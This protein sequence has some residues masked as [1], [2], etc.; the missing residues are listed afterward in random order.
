MVINWGAV[1]LGGFL[2]KMVQSTFMSH[3][4]AACRSLIWKHIRTNLLVR[5]VLGA[6][7]LLPAEFPETLGPVRLCDVPGIGRLYDGRRSSQ[8]DSGASG[9][10]WNIL[11]V[12]LLEVTGV[13]APPGTISLQMSEEVKVHF[14]QTRRKLLGL[15]AE[16]TY[17]RW[18]Y[19][20]GH[21]RLSLDAYNDD[22]LAVACFLETGGWMYFDDARNVLAV[23]TVAPA[24][25]RTPETM[26]FKK[27]AWKQ[28]WTE[29]LRNHNRFHEVTLDFMVEVGARYFVW[30][31]PH[32]QIGDGEQPILPHGGFAYLFHSPGDLT[33]S[34]SALDCYFAVDPFLSFP[35]VH[36]RYRRA[37]I[38]PQQAHLECQVRWYLTDSKSQFQRP[39][40]QWLEIHILAGTKMMKRINGTKDS[41]IVA[42]SDSEDMEVDDEKQSVRMKHVA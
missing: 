4:R 33:N 9:K 21:A 17:F 29:H 39:Q 37:N 34:K 35:T 27:H 12:R 11:N 28:E 7:R 3:I 41:I 16:A 38:S 5:Q 30:L 18:C 14:G 15:P 42:V 10:T 19:P 31:Y 32:E 22:H 20:C 36:A 24:K 13:S 2:L 25:D 6:F 1:V 23:K 26:S 40:G 8:D